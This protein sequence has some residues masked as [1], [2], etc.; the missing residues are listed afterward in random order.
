MARRRSLFDNA[1]LQFD[2]PK[3]GYLDSV[4]RKWVEPTPEKKSVKGD[5]Q[6][7]IAT[8]K[9]QVIVP[10]G[11]KLNDAYMFICGVDLPTIEEKKN[12]FSANTTIKGRKYYILTKL[13]FSCGNLSTDGYFYIL[14]LKKLPEG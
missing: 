14:A 6:P 8:A 7:Y 11:Y 13:D 9:D 2:I 1:T 3:E 12:S 5:L 4:T 10:E